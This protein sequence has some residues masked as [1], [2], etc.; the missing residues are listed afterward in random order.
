MKRTRDDA[1]RMLRNLGFQPT[2][3]KSPE[4]KLGPWVFA[5]EH[6][7]QFRTVCFRKG[8]KGNVQPGLKRK[9]PEVE[10]APASDKSKGWYFRCPIPCESC[11][12]LLLVR[13][14]NASP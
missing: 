1:V 3:H 7:R 9:L 2:H 4:F 6:Q 8:S 13:L 11:L 14:L 12:A 10:C 5:F